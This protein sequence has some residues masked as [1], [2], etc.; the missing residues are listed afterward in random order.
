MKANIAALLALSLLAAC[1][2]GGKGENRDEVAA[3]AGVTS[4][5]GAKIGGPFTLVGQDGQPVSWSDFAGKYRIVYFGYTFCPDVCPLDL[6]NIMRGY[7][8][9]AAQH[10]D[11]AKKVQAMFISV[12]PQRDT[13]A[14]VKDYIANFQP[15]KGGLPLI[16]LTGDADRIAGVAKDFAV[17]YSHEKPDA[18]GGYYVAHTRTPYFFDPQGKPLALIPVDDPATPE[19]EGSPQ[20]IAAF[21]AGMVKDR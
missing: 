7:D 18:S 17:A 8:L 11:A 21:L 16:G 14:V 13:P 19:Q 20:A 3:M 1:S 6:Q 4:L 5:E 15:K 2:P 10:P 9:F 12:D